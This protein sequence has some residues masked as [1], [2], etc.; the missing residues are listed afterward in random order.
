L[1]EL[2]GKLEEKYLVS[3]E[4]PSFGRK[5]A[6]VGRIVPAGWNYSGEDWYNYA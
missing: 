5:N 4:F 3:V 2:S 1:V 6:E